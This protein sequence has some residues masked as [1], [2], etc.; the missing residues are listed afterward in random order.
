MEEFLGKVS[1]YLFRSC[2]AYNSAVLVV[3]K[4]KVLWHS[5]KKAI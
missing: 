1:T 3:K 5:T 2:F 4:G